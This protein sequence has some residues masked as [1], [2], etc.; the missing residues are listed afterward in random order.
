MWRL[1]LK[2]EE[3][4][5]S[6][7][8]QI[9]SVN[10][11]RQE[12]NRGPG[13]SQR[14]RHIDVSPGRLTWDDRSPS[15]KNKSVVSTG[16]SGCDYML[17]QPQKTNTH[18]LAFSLDS[19]RQPVD[20]K[21][22]Q[23]PLNGLSTRC[24]PKSPTSSLTLY[25]SAHPPNA[26]TSSSFSHKHPV[27]SSLSATMLAL[28]A[29]VLASHKWLTIIL[30]VSVQISLRPSPSSSQHPKWCTQVSFSCL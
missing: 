30:Q 14:C 8:R 1:V 11:K 15:S 10:W 24:L 7:R 13:G 19:G 23:T 25:P 27:L 21:S 29:G 12:G 2:V 26:F 22:V 16:Q 9:T 4:T 20:F 3:G 5:K 18:S 6:Q 17:Q 28:F